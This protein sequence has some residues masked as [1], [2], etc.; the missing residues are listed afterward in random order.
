VDDHPLHLVGFG[1]DEAKDASL[2]LA[3]LEVTELVEVE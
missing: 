1:G 3:S 2:G